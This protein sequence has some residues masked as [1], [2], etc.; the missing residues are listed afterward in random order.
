VD[1]TNVTPVGELSGAATCLVYYRSDG[2]PEGETKP[3]AK[4]EKAYESDFDDRVNYYNRGILAYN[5]DLETYIGVELD[6]D[7]VNDATQTAVAKTVQIIENNGDGGGLQLD[8]IDLYPPEV[9]MSQFNFELPGQTDPNGGNIGWLRITFPPQIIAESKNDPY[10]PENYAAAIDAIGDKFPLAGMPEQD[11][12]GYPSFWY[13]IDRADEANPAVAAAM[14]YDFYDPSATNGEPKEIFRAI[15]QGTE[16]LFDIGI[17]Y[18]VIDNHSMA[19]GCVTALTDV[20]YTDG[21]LN[22]GIVS[23]FE[24]YGFFLA[25]ELDGNR[26][27]EAQARAVAE[28]IEAKMNYVS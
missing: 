1:Y 4:A 2:L 11:E 9:V 14:A 13:F 15:S 17:R 23:Y 20:F 3:H 8:A 6:Y 21:T 19:P 18:E 24:D 27:T 7:C 28:S 26:F 10:T 22:H 12:D 16:Y 25:V 5:F